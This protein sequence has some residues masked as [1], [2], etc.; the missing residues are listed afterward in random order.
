VEG[1][2]NIFRDLGFANPELEM[3]ICQEKYE[4]FIKQKKSDT[5]EGAGT[6]PFG[7]KK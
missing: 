7:R 4:L 6:Y 3:K 1:S 5:V 2:D